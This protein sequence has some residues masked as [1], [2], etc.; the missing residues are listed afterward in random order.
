MPS[1]L[2]AGSA[3]QV[4]HGIQDML[5][6]KDRFFWHVDLYIHG[7]SPDQIW[8]VSH[9]KWLIAYPVCVGRDVLQFLWSS[10]LSIFGKDRPNLIPIWKILVKIKPLIG[11]KVQPNHV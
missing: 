5:Y 3:E 6:L 2:S 1:H 8:H 7:S 9:V 4:D 11:L 10:K